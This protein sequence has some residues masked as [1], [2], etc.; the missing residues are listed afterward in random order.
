MTFD[1]PP[2]SRDVVPAQ[3]GTHNHRCFVLS[4]SSRTLRHLAPLAGKGRPP[5]RS[6]GGRV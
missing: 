5:E 4:R 1:I 3:A 6:G 2:L